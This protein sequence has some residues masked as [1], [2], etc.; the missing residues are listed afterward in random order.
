MTVSS[1]HVGALPFA[2]DGLAAAVV[3]RSG[4][5]LRWT[6]TAQ[7]LTGFTAGEVCGR[8]V[9][10]LLATDPGGPGAAA[11]REQA[12]VPASGRVP[13]RHRPQGTV[14]AVYRATPMDGPGGSLILAAP[15][16]RVSGRERNGALLSALSG[17]G[18]LEV[19][20]YDM[21][22][23]VVQTG[24]TA[25]R[26]V[27]GP[28][29]AGGGRLGDA[30]AAE[31]A[32]RVEGLLRR[33]LST[34]VPV[35]RSSERMTARDDPEC[36]WVL[37]WSAVRLEDAR[38]RPAGVV[39]VLVDAPPES[40]PDRRR[41]DL[42]REMAERVGDSLDV[43]RTAQELAEVLAP[44]FADVAAVDLLQ[45]V[46]D[47]EEPPHWS[48]DGDLLRGGGTFPP[49]AGWAPGP[50]PDGVPV[51][52]RPGDLGLR[53][54]RYGEA[55]ALS[56]EEVAAA[57]GSRMD[58]L[59]L[60]EGFHSVAVAPLAARGLALGAVSAWRTGD[61]EP[62]T[63]DDAAL[64]EAA[65]TRGA[66]A[67]DNA[68]RYT[69]EHRA[70]GVLQQRLLPPA[71]TDTPAAE[72]AGVYL[73]AG[74]GEA[75]GGDWFDAIPLPS[76]RLALVA[77]DVF[78]HGIHASA[79]MGRLRTAIQTLADLEL[80]PEELLTR[81]GD[82]VQRLANESEPY[83]HDVVVGATCL[84]AV[85][86]PVAGHCVIASAGHPPPILL[87]A[88]GRAEVVDVSPGPPFPVG[89][90]PYEST[91]VALP[92][93]SVLAL[94]T[95]GLIEQDEQGHVVSDLDQ[96]TQRLAA[97]L[98]TVYR[99]DR[100]LAET[101]H[102]V[103]AELG[104]EAPRD[105][106]ALMLARARAI[107]GENRADWEFSADLEAVAGAREATAR[108]LAEWGL[109]DL[110]FTTELIVSELV[111]NAVRHAR[112]PIRLRLIRDGVLVCEVCDASATQPR[113]RRARTTDE[114]G[115]GLFIVAQLASRW[116]CR[117]GRDGKTIWAEQPIPRS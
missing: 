66:I 38:G 91:T 32:E 85:H 50:V 72:T 82:L 14:D 54:G 67:L 109:D 112:P 12:D 63:A 65:A 27:C 29:R 108:Q 114:G 55:A 34:G 46:F 75:I 1:P 47:G 76:F 10:D 94:Y 105:D 95:D 89:G 18:R 117:Y 68:R 5:V 49:D 19:A 41:V 48:G 44:G 81:V 86:D 61:S 31:D 77:G 25:G 104:I 98:T 59:P 83:Y 116:G 62:F 22:L 110:A 96:G 64:L 21:D 97:A 74:G 71:T 16:Q 103:L 58:E 28:D 3:D 15:A 43:A 37:C 93:G 13:L 17:E 79:T 80:D 23:S 87:R 115:R 8:H 111:T 56:R 51:L 45:G 101:G 9:S 7:G 88:D 57:L 26:A 53:H 90:T 6:V 100:A 102:A 73:P 78:G 39:S 70:A 2:F 35:I 24:A 60:P 107:P 52:R 11:D 106:V 40:P 4:T 113:M 36:Q 99:P 33:V 92:P 20:L 69:H 42:V 84:Y 30:A